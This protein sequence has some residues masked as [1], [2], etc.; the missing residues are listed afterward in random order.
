MSYLQQV[1]NAYRDS[2]MEMGVSEDVINFALYGFETG[3]TAGT[4]QNDDIN[5]QQEMVKL[6]LN[7]G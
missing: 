3:F 5:L 7:K 1:S 2:M 6:I 4:L